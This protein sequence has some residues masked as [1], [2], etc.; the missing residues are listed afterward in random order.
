MSPGG[1]GVR[2]LGSGS[3]P[4]VA[5]LGHTEL[6]GGPWSR[7]NP[8][9]QDLGPPCIPTPGALAEP[10]S[11]S[12]EPSLFPWGLS[13]PS[14]PR[15]GCPPTPAHWRHQ[16]GGSAAA[17]WAPGEVHQGAPSWRAPASEIS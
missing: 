13:S 11:S 2:E 10:G 16:H 6:S 1:V 4:G 9:P 17:L 8:D 7:G 5:A 14:T 3:Q 15:E 12:R